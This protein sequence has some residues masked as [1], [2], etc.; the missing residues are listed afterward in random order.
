MNIKQCI[1]VLV[2]VIID[3][4]RRQSVGC[5]MKGIGHLLLPKECHSIVIRFVSHVRRKR[6]FSEMDAAN[7]LTA[8]HELIVSNHM[9]EGGYQR[10]TK[11][12][13]AYFNLRRA[14]IL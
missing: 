10:E 13:F 7:S 9:G 14:C 2:W 6:T 12:P 5:L 11:G 3:D 4:K 8:F 1:S